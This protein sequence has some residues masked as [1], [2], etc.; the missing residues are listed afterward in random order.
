MTICCEDICI[1]VT[2][3]RVSGFTAV[4]SNGNFMLKYGVFGGGGNLQFLCYLYNEVNQ[5]Y[6]NTGSSQIKYLH[7]V[8]KMPFP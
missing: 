7:D 1:K 4:L 8:T 6:E 3:H 5:K 2:V